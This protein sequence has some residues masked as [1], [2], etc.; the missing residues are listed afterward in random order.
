MQFVVAGAIIAVVAGGS[1]TMYEARK[2]TESA[3]KPIKALTETIKETGKLTNNITVG[4]IAA[5][6]CYIC[7]PYLRK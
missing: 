4:L 2:L 5:T 3:E 1:Y 6:A 7:I